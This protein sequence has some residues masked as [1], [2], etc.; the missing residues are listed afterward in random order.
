MNTFVPQQQQQ[1][2]QQPKAPPADGVATVDAA[3][4]GSADQPVPAPAAARRHAQ[5]AERAFQRWQQ[6]GA[7]PGGDV[8]DWL[9]AEREIDDEA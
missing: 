5:I 3:N 9:A 2:D 6:R 4:E 7:V 8:D 1:Q